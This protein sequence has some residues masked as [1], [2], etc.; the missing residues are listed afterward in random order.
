MNPRRFLN[1]LRSPSGALTLFLL[2]LMI[3]LVMVNS[4]REPGGRSGPVTP[5][6]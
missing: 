6:P 5:T 4:R 2:G 3:V 1:L